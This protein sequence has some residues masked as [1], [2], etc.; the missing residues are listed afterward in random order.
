MTYTITDQC[1]GCDR[2]Y[3]ACPTHAV[4]LS[5]TSVW[6]DATL[7]NH[8]IG[9]YSVPQCV[10][11]C[12]TNRACVMSPTNYWEQWFDTYNTRI[13]RLDRTRDVAYWNW[14]FELYSQRLTTQILSQ[15]SSTSHSRKLLQLNT[16]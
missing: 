4:Q 10:A 5:A 2:C 15:S 9:S 7:C 11:A 13:A 6:I 1:I 3:S 12:P 16:H 8:C 14:W